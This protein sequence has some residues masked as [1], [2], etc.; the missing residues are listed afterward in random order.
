[1]KLRICLILVTILNISCQSVGAVEDLTSKS[2]NTEMASKTTDSKNSVEKSKAS[3]S[4]D[5]EMASKTTDSKD[6]VDKPKASNS[7][8]PTSTSKSH[9]T[10]EPKS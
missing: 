5:T 9:N 1:M 3:N 2:V 7:K 10:E 8:D 4:H 6:S